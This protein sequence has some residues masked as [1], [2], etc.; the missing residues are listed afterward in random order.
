VRWRYE[1]AEELL[2]ERQAHL[3]GLVLQQAHAGETAGPC[4]EN[5]RVGGSHEGEFPIWKDLE[6]CRHEVAFQLASITKS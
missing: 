1:T 5:I 6:A 3:P 2:L 4:L